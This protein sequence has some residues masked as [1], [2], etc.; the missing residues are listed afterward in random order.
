[1]AA[2][3]ALAGAGSGSAAF[4]D[5]VV[6]AHRQGVRVPFGILPGVPS[7]GSPNGG[8]RLYVP[9][10]AADVYADP[11]FSPLSVVVS[12]PPLVIVPPPF[13]YDPFAWPYDAGG[14]FVQSD[15]T[16]QHGYYGSC[17]EAFYRQ[18]MSR[19]D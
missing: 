5:G 14:C 6:K 7:G 17:A 12:P 13:F 10:Y 18:W 9:P 15:N 8:V 2:S 3:L 1:L 16:G 11:Y 4:A 19:P